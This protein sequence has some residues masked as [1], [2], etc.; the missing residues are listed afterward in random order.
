MMKWKRLALACGV[1]ILLGILPAVA[2]AHAQ[3][4][5]SEPIAGAVLDSAP[6]RV[7]LFFSEPI[8]P[9]FSLIQVFGVDGKRFDRNDAHIMADNIAALEATL[10][11]LPPGGYTVSWRVLSIDSHVVNGTFSFSVGAAAAAAPAGSSVVIAGSSLTLDATARW[12]TFLLAFA[13]AGG[14]AFIPLILQPALQ[15]AGITDTAP[16]RFAAR[17]LVWVAWPAVMLL[18]VLSLGTLVLQAIDATGLPLAEVFSQGALTRLLVE[19]KYGTFWIIRMGL[20]VGLLCVVVGLSIDLRPRNAINMLGVG[21]AAAVLLTFSLGGHASAVVQR[22]ILAIAADWAHLLAGAI[23][24]GGLLQ[25]ALAL[26]AALRRLTLTERRALLGRAIQ[27][28]SLVAGLSVAVLIATGIY[29]GLLHI[30]SWISLEDTVYGATLSGKVLLVLPLLVLGG[31]NLLIFHPRFVRAMQARSKAPED[32]RGMRTFRRIVLGELTLMLVVLLI[33][34][35]L[36]ELPPAT[37]EGDAAKPVN[38]T[39]KAGAY[40]ITLDVTPNQAGTNQIRISVVDASG[41]PADVPKV[42]LAMDH[43]DMEMGARLVDALPIAP[44]VYQANGGY[45]SMAGRWHV[46]VTLPQSGTAPETAS[47][48]FAVGRAPGTKPPSFSPLLILANALTLRTVA[49]IIALG[50]AGLILVQRARMRRPRQRQMSGVMGMILLLVGLLTCGS[51]LTVAYQDSLPNP[52]PATPASIARGRQIYV[53]NCASCHGLTG[54]GD[55]PAGARLDPRPAD[56]RVHMAAGH[57]DAQLFNWIANGVDGTAMPGWGKVL[58]RDEI[59]S[60]LNFIR[61]F[62]PGAAQP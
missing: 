58:T 44:G 24:V 55:G 41:R 14:L 42:S 7:R 8:E 1:L 32:T 39:E 47:F 60:V 16:R 20:L 40:S 27:R 12:L 45:L 18:F 48:Q 46:A 61:T 9:G 23:W 21:I 37:T 43:L 29:A 34:G 4:V 51:A 49:G 52:V 35:F 53:T 6:D 56:F 10:Q 30:P 15:K 25:F 11:P 2:L 5:R 26:P 28:F 50:M 62:A 38:V 17:R 3:L 31:I 59:G 33:T 57:T 54:R 13:L 36:T 19:T 22:P